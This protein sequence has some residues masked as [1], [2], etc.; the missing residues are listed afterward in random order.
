MQI[1]FP[2]TR[3]TLHSLIRNDAEI[4]KMYSE[5]RTKKFRR[6]L[7]KIKGED[8]VQEIGAVL[9]RF[10]TYDLIG[11]ILAVINPLMEKL[12]DAASKGNTELSVPDDQFYWRKDGKVKP[13]PGCIDKALNIAC[14][15]LRNH[16]EI[17]YREEHTH[18][19]P[20]IAL[21]IRRELSWSLPNLPLQP[22]PSI[23]RPK[24][25]DIRR[26]FFESLMYQ[27]VGSD[28]RLEIDDDG[29]ERAA[30]PAAW[31]IT[32]PASET[33]AGK[34]PARKVLSLPAHKVFLV[35]AEW[36]KKMFT[37]GMQEMQAAM[38]SISLSGYRYEIVDAMFHFLYKGSIPKPFF[39]S[40]QADGAEELNASDVLELL[41]LSD[42]TQFAALQ[43]LCLE[44]LGQGISAKN[45]LMYAQHQVASGVDYMT[46]ILQWFIKMNPKFDQDHSYDLS[47]TDP[48]SL[49]EIYAFAQSFHLDGLTKKTVEHSTTTFQYDD[50]FI[51]AC[52]KVEKSTNKEL[53]KALKELVKCN[54]DFSGNLRT[55]KK[56][57]LAYATACAEL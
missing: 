40:A 16:C 52:E 7:N 42:Y 51:S 36:F 55:N 13:C 20:F 39:Y 12:R 9:E 48:Y 41:R 32:L 4:Q 19:L 23:D 25:A 21:N 1:Q 5:T 33:S 31:K 2:L 6:L 22:L 14:T 29:K 24:T 18:V 54:P 53:L 37:V 38:P 56:H 11:R 46:K 3:D 49:I 35:Q 45:F 17:K 47:D 27:E 15:I 28:M 50:A 43:Q 26:T 34:M 8:P 57:F 30:V 10:E 44:K